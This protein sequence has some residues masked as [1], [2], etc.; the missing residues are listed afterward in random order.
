MNANLLPNS[1]SAGL[2]SKRTLFS[3]EKTVR[4]V[5]SNQLSVISSR[6]ATESEVGQASRLSS[7]LRSQATVPWKSNKEGIFTGGNRVN[8]VEPGTQA[9]SKFS[10]PS[11][12]SCEKSLVFPARV[13]FVQPPTE[14]TKW[15]T[16]ETPVLLFRIEF[17]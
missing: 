1:A 3:V 14:Q 12:T 15:A 16:G 2:L 5:I 6:Q 4:A 9:M 11:V 8:R 7:V 17:V 13:W 10:V